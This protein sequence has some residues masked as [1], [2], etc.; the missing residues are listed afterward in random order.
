MA[1]QIGLS[2]LSN[3]VPPQP[4]SRGS[5]FGRFLTPRHF[6][7]RRAG[8]AVYSIAIVALGGTALAAYFAVTSA[9]Q[10]ASG[11][12]ASSGE[13]VGATRILDVKVIQAARRSPPDSVEQ[14]TGTVEPRRVS[15]LA[16]KLGGRI[17]SVTVDVGAEVEPSQVLASLDRTQVLAQIDASKAAF[18]SAKAQLSELENGPRGQDIAAA[19]STVDE[20]RAALKLRQAAF[21]RADRLIASRSIS[22]EEHDQASYALDAARARLTAAQQDLA[23]LEE[24]SRQE[25]IAAA[26]ANVEQLS[27]QIRV[28]ESDLR[29]REI[30]APFYGD[31]QA[32]FVDEGTIVA[33]GQQILQIVEKPPYEVRVAVPASIVGCM[34]EE[35][36]LVEFEGRSLEASIARIAPAITQ[37][38]QTREVVLELSPAS[39]LIAPLGGAVSVSVES[40][41]LSQGLWVPTS[42]LTAGSRGLWTVYVAR[43]ASNTVDTPAYSNNSIPPDTGV[44]ERVQVELLRAGEEWSEIQGPLSEGQWVVATGT[45]RI[46]NKQRVRCIQ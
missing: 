44:V 36:F 38:T 2:T 43:P 45:H 15:I 8:I 13:L 21:A 41:Q 40:S 10:P 4:R 20:S 14:F 11:P 42:A 25:Q 30:L 22:E 24:G 39:S 33:P 18:E 6:M 46:S 31:I 17:E 28:L 35:R 9:G 32:R 37:T 19:R 34:E 26:R 27:A 29:E 12:P 3:L 7:T 5:F 1:L 16:S 23:K